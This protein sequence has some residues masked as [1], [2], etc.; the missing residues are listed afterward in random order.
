MESIDALAKAVNEFSGGLVLVSHDMRLISQVAKEIWICDHKT[1]TPYKGDILNFKMDMRAQM[2]IQGEQKAAQLLRGDASQA[3]KK[4]ADDK[5]KADAKKKEEAAA[6]K[7]AAEAKL[8]FI[9]P[10]RVAAATAG[11]TAF[12]TTTMANS[13]PQV[14]PSSLAAPSAVKVEAPTLTPVVTPA[15]VPAAAATDGAAPVRKAYIPPH[16]RRKMQE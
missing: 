6:K 12:E 9:P 5:K 7:A 15:P 11:A 13:L 14:V 2:G 16:L 4:D 1:V 10:P 3:K 8:E